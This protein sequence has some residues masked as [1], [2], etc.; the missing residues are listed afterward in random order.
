[1]LHTVDQGDGWLR[2]F[3]CD[4]GKP[5]W[6]FNMNDRS[7]QRPLKKHKSLRVVESPAFD[8]ERLYVVAVQSQRVHDH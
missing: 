2:A 6:Q 4:T 3:D 7:S 1:M 5:V 8:G